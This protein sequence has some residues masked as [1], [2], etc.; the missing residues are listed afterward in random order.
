[1]AGIKTIT[2]TV[3]GTIRLEPYALDLLKTV[4]M[5]RLNSIRQTGG[6]R[7]ELKESA[8]RPHGRALGT[9]LINAAPPL[10]AQCAPHHGAHLGSLLS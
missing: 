3:H 1:M 2:D 6:R 4:E 5:Q 8:R 7:R 10:A 9:N